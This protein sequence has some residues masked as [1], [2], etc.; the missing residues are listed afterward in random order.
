M[1]LGK[2][3]ALTAA[4]VG[5]MAL[6][7]WVGPYLTDRTAKPASTAAAHVTEPASARSDTARPK[8]AARP[9]TQATHAE[10]TN[11]TAITTD[12]PVSAPRLHRR[13]RPL[14]KP[15]A[16]MSIVSKGFR[17][18]EDLAATVHASKNID[19]PFM[20]LKHRVVEEGKSLQTAIHESKPGVNASAAVERARQEARSDLASL[21]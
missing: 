4:L 5:A 1:T 7:V 18:A 9:R 6:G 21:G 11:E 10:A 13:L 2:A 8:P 3:T 15:G 20:V 19:V 17:S 12:I 14:L 16:D